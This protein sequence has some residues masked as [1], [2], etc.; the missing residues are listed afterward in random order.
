M[1]LTPWLFAYRNLAYHR[2][3]AQ[4]SSFNIT[5]VC[6]YDLSVERVNLVPQGIVRRAVRDVRGHAAGVP[7]SDD[8][9]VMA[10]RNRG[11]R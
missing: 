3:R 11:S 10:I 5:I 1:S 4:A 2:L 8:V 7:Q 9:T 6:N